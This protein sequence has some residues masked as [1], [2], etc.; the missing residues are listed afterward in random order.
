MQKRV[1]VTGMG[2]VTPLGLTIKDTWNALIQGHSGVS[3]ISRFDTQDFPCKIA[4]E[5]KNYNPDL[6]FTKQEARRL[7]RFS[8]FAVVAAREALQDSGLELSE[9]EKLKTGVI[10]GVGMG[11]VEVVENA[12][13]TLKE[14]GVR[15]LSPLV[16]PL[17][18]PNLAA[19]HVSIQLGLKG[20]NVCTTTACA[21]GSHAIGDA[22]KHIQDGRALMMLAGGAESVISPLGIGAFCACKALSTRND[23]PERASRPFDEERDGFVMGEG[24][25]ILVLEELDHAQKR[26]ANIYAEIVGYGLNS[27]AYHITNP[28]EGGE[29]AARCMEMALSDARL[30]K[31]DIGYVNAHGTST[32][33]GDIAESSALKTVFKDQAKNLC[34]SSTKS[35][36]G[37]LLGASGGVE[38][39]FSVLALKNSK[40][41][42]TINL[43]NQ[44]K[45]C[46]LNYIPNETIEKNVNFVLSNSFGFGGTNASL[47]FKKI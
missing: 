32:K 47:I 12:V 3:L 27:D 30:S 4:A 14:K 41:P 19:G 22:F 42:P 36:T 46:D 45:E 2:A 35:M 5:I 26:K 13:L 28:S 25:G 43:E 7:E 18:I 23:A 9:E 44:D 29:G 8:Q 38:A 1:V 16:I 31:E 6:Y 33:A 24:S 39:I 40:L 10:V 17:M 20:P 34:V 37:H 21:A 15:R 11:G